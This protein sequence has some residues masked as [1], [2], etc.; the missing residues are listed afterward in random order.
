MKKKLNADGS[1]IAAVPLPSATPAAAPDHEPLNR[2]PT[3]QNSAVEEKTK[4]ADT[5]TPDTDPAA[6]SKL[7]LSDA[8]YQLYR[9]KALQR[10]DEFVSYLNVITN[11]SLST[12]QK[13]EAIDQAVKLFM[14]A[15]TIEVTSNSRPGSRRYPIR[16]Y[17]SRLKLLPYSSA[18]IEWSE[19]QYIK[20]MSQA[21]DGN[22]YGVI[23]GQQTFVGYGNKG[24][25]VLYSD[26][27]PKRVRVKLERRQVTFNGADV[28]NWNLLL[29]NIGVAA[30]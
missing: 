14:P 6:T 19:V 24:D 28:V 12:V 26:V 2:A 18:K 9:A 16:Q 17:L 7:V 3:I 15:A 30:N 10:V 1:P 21:A 22:Y 25:N 13:D 23:T 29:G 5:N 11:K 4:E 8:D 27:T 20:E